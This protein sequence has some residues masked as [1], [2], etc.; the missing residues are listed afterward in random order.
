MPISSCPKPTAAASTTDET[1]VTSLR[2]VCELASEGRLAL[3]S[4]LG[5]GPCA[6]GSCDDPIPS[7]QRWI[8]IGPKDNK[9]DFDQDL[10]RRKSE[11][12]LRGLLDCVLRCR[13]RIENGDPLIRKPSGKRFR[14]VGGRGIRTRRCRE[15]EAVG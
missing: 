9:R 11:G 4:S 7:I 6:S 1:L 3:R 10:L 5:F 13:E 14:K 15:N 2:G 12:L 8:V